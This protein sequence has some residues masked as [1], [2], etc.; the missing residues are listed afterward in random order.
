MKL[1]GEI[2]SGPPVHTGS[3]KNKKNLERVVQGA[4]GDTYVLGFD[5]DTPKGRMSGCERGRCL[6]DTE[7]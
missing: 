6:G 2:K 3:R 4:I 1:T 7:N 5:F